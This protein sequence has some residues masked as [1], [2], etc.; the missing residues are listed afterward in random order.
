M[1]T[2][3]SAAQAHRGVNIAVFFNE[4]QADFG[5]HRGCRDNILLLRLLYDQV[6]S[7]KECIYSEY[8]VRVH[9]HIHRLHCN[10]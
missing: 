5:A 4:W 6:I 7:N 10:V 3:G 8:T 1:T 9:T 2:V